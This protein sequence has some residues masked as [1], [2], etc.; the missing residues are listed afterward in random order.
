MIYKICEG[1]DIKV[2]LAPM[3]GND[4]WIKKCKKPV[5]KIP[6]VRSEAVLKF[7]TALNLPAQLDMA[8][9]RN[10]EVNK[11]RKNSIPIKVPPVVKSIIV[12]KICQAL[13]L[14]AKLH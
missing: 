5:K 2:Q 7:C 4:T 8:E 10:V 3:G 13:G 1:L 11:Q 14:S 6:T 12:Y 9:G